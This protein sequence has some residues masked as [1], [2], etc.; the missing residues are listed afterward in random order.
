MTRPRPHRLGPLEL[1]VLDALWS[2]GPA[3]VDRVHESVGSPRHLARNTIQSTLERLVRKG[4]AT[5]RKLGRAFE[6]RADLS[7]ADWAAR[8]LRELLDAIPRSDARLMVA[9]F[10]ELTERAG[11]ESLAELEGLV[12]ERRRARDEEPR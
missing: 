9:T 1:A 5:R 3:N 11:E 8:S 4:L 10:A 7:R 6:Y 12:R 2:G